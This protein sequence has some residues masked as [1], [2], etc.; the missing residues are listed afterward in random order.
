MKQKE[1]ILI[2]ED[3]P[4]QTMVL[5]LG[6]EQYG[7]EVITAKDGIE[8]AGK[9]Y[10]LSPDLIISDIMMPELN[11][12]QFCRLIKNDSKVNQIPVILLTNLGQQQDRFWGEEAGADNYVVKSNDLSKL[13]KTIDDLLSKPKSNPVEFEPPDDNITTISSDSVKSRMNYL[14]DRLLFESTIS[15]RIREIA[16]Y[17]YDTKELMTNLFDLLSR[18]L[19]YSVGCLMIEENEIV[20]IN[21]KINKKL[22][23]NFLF[24]FKQD[25]LQ[26]TR[27]PNI[28]NKTILYND[29]LLS[30]DI[31]D[32]DISFQSKIIIPFQVKDDLWATLALFDTKPDRYD[33]DTQ[34]LVQ[35]ICKELV[36]LIRYI[37]KLNEIERIKADFTSMIVHDL[38]SP[39]SGVFALLKLIRENRVG[40]VNEKQKEMLSQILSTLNKVLNLVNDV[41]DVSKLESGRIDLILKGT[42]FND[43]IE[44]SIHNICILAE[45]K[46]IKIVNNFPASCSKITGDETKLEQV[47]INLLSNSIKF[48]PEHS[49]IIISGEKV[50]NKN[51]ESKWLKFSIQDFGI[52]IS[53]DAIN[54]IF[55]K[56]MQTKTGQNSV[57]KGTGLGLAICKMIIHAHGGKIWAESQEGRGS[58]F[59]FTLPI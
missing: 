20:T 42:D 11:G 18:L 21:I 1:K 48:S 16:Q 45:E 35:F 36:M 9:V 31:Q 13:T 12:Y 39:L 14:L 10:S 8:G 23:R 56:Y 6:L 52:G 25:L 26:Y 32:N 55:D 34:Q 33:S 43:I 19:D 44:E 57:K 49:R 54:L 24:Q 40:A 30:D 2:V 51:D 46:D 5:K 27:F 28:Q 41:L 7:F 47:I 4:T 50:F 59:H 3:S 37:A 58:T 17:A 38:R 53:N 29:K 15:S 22:N